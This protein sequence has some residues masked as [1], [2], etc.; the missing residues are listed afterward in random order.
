MATN[1]NTDGTDTER[2]KSSKI[3]AGLY[4]VTK[5]S[6]TFQIERA[7]D[8]HGNYVQDQWH[9]FEITDVGAGRDYWQT[10]WTKWEAMEV[11][12][13]FVGSEIENLNRA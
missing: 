1:H 11:I 13:S 2:Q 12:T 5:G 6:R 7:S 4:E 8:E 10:F 9:L 3:T